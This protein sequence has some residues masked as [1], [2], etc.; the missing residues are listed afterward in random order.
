M[1]GVEEVAWVEVLPKTTSPNNLINQLLTPTAAEA[2][3]GLLVVSV[4]A[5]VLWT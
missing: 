4:V 5:T 2:Y 1:L 3:R